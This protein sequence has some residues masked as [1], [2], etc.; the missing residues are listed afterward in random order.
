MKDSSYNLFENLKLEDFSIMPGSELKLLKGLELGCTGIITA[1]CNVTA[2]LARRVYDDFFL[3][4][5]QSHNQKL[6]EIR[7]AF[8][9]YNLISGLHTLCSLEN[10]IYK[11]ILP[12]LSLLNKK[13]EKELI[14]SLKNLNFKN[15][16]L[17]AA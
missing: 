9:K 8:D 14:N 17:L 2:Q 13:E 7:S 11:N 12:P 10:R 5:E 1:T 4:K 6:C 16:P 3:G 15:K